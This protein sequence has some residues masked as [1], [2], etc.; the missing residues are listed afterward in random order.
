MINSQALPYTRLN[1]LTK[2]N[3]TS[4]WATSMSIVAADV[5]ALS[6][7]YWITVIGRYLLNP[8]YDLHFYMSLYP[9]ITLFVGAFYIQNLYPG[10]LIHPAEEIRR[11]FKCVTIVF[12]LIALGTFLGHNSDVYSRSIF[13]IIWASGAPSILLAR[14]LVRGVL[15]KQSWWGIPAVILGQGPCAE[16]VIHTLSK[17]N[18]GL[19][20]AGILTDDLST[21]SAQGFP[22]VLGN[23]SAAHHWAQN[24]MAKYVI[25]ALPGKTNSELRYIIQ[26]FCRSFR[27]VL[28]VPDLPGICSLGIVTHE[29]GGEVGL[30]LPQR[31][32]HT[33]ANLTKRLFDLVVSALFLLCLAPIF[34]LIAVAIKLTSKGPIFFG[35][36]RY[37]QDGE[38]FKA[39]KFRTMAQDADQLLASHLEAHPE[40]RAEWERDHKLR[41]DPRVTL[42]GRFLRR[43][44]LDE[45]PQLLNVLLGQMS[46]VGPRPIVKNEIVKYGDGYDLYTRVLPGITGLWQVSGRN[47]TTYAERVAFDEYYVRNWSVWL[48]LY[49]LTKTVKT[50]IKAEGA[51]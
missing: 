2:V 30:E 37:G 50:V 38:L 26:N 40:F 13:L 1:F 15:S 17:G 36:S 4:I 32:C 29:I 48:D 43:Y 25:V 42:V 34:Y 22:P 39:L 33:W 23:L 24:R 19:R 5:F 21:Y 47:N 51:Y 44:S 6:A 28:L 12:L 31:L 9:V 46:L 18:I 35:H 16:R 45:L 3:L 49:I 11:V 8:N 7:V 27:H 14:H 20:I 10:I 41:K